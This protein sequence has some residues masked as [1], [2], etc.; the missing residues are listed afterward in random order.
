MKKRPFISLIIPV[1][2]VEKY[3]KKC[4][5]SIINQTFTDFEIILVDDGSKDNSGIICDEYATKDSRILVIHKDNGGVSS[6]RNLGIIKAS[7]DWILFVD[8][9]DVVPQDTL[10][11]YANSIASNDIDM[12][13]GSYATCDENDNIKKYN[14]NQFEKTISILDCLKLFYH[15]DTKLFQGYIWN[16]P[17]KRSII[18]DHHLFFN[19]SIYFKED[20]LFAVQYMLCCTKKCL[21]SS[22]VVYYY[23]QHDNSSMHLY[24][25]KVSDKYLTNLDARILCLENIRQKYNDRSLINKAKYS[26]LAFYYQIKSRICMTEYNTLIF[27]TKLLYRLIK[28]IG[29][30]YY[31]RFR[32]A[33]FKGFLYKKLFLTQ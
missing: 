17:M 6:A 28:S 29:I 4:V 3:L 24:N 30:T 2:N 18:M 10:L 23:Y 8:A 1:Y 16:R 25:S 7:G 26:V 5:D 15:S 13:L 22:R 33:T 27:K 21:Y 11:Y 12:I 31:A 20:G 9:D 32:F 14:T 19:E